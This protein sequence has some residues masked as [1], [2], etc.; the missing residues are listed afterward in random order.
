MKGIYALVIFLDADAEIKIGAL[1]KIDFAKG[2]Y[3][4]VGSAQNS[5][6]KRVKR[7]LRKEKKLF[8]HIDYLLNCKKS[9]IT[10]VFYDQ[11]KKTEECVVAKKIKE[12]GCEIIAFGCSDCKCSSHLFHIKNAEIIDK[13][14]KQLDLNQSSSNTSYSC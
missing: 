14:M 9:K 12:H 5:I 11:S 2:H 4:Y 6:E 7:H 13:S 3:V 1:G 8:W 10:K